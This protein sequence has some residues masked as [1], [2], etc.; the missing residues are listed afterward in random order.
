M[1]AVY[2][3]STSDTSDR[4]SGA[5]ETSFCRRSAGSSSRANGSL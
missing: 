1:D 4:P 3:W 2:L 5:S